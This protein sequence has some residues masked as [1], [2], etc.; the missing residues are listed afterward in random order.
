MP[1]K[2]QNFLLVSMLIFV[3]MLFGSCAR[4]EVT[5]TPL[6]DKE[7]SQWDN[8]LSYRYTEEFDGT[9]PKDSAGNLIPPVGAN[10]DSYGIFTVIEE[11]NQPVLKV[12]GE[13]Y[14]CISTKASYENYHFKLKVK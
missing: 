3:S 10:K 12:S 2:S 7:L 5:W 8:Y 4:E 1:Y 9:Q 6:L 11:N 14:G 13:I